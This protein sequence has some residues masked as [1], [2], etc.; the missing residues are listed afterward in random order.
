VVLCVNLVAP[1]VCRAVVHTMNEVKLP[2]VQEDGGA[3]T[4]SDIESFCPPMEAKQDGKDEGGSISS[5]TDPTTS[6]PEEK[7]DGESVDES[8]RGIKTPGL[9]ETDRIPTP[10][11]RT[12]VPREQKQACSSH[13]HAI[14]AFEA[15]VDEE[16]DT[17]D[18]EYDRDALVPCD[19]GYSK[20][21]RTQRMEFHWE[22]YSIAEWEN[23]YGPSRGAW[24]NAY[25]PQHMNYGGQYGN[26]YG[27]QYGH[28]YGNYRPQPYGAE[29]KRP[30]E[31]YHVHST[32]DMFSSSHYG[33]PPQKTKKKNKKKAKSNHTHNANANANAIGTWGGP[34]HSLVGAGTGEGRSTLPAA[35]MDPEHR[36]HRLESRR[37]D[38]ARWKEKEDYIEYRRLVPKHARSGDDPVSP[39]VSEDEV[40]SM[41]KREWKYNCERWQRAVKTRVKK[42]YENLESLEHVMN[43][44]S[45]AEKKKEQAI[46]DLEESDGA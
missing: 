4:S 5:G 44:I 8:T 23:V 40:E 26:Q 9:I 39:R 43:R 36:Q 29:R 3:T 21:D 6:P 41:S 14:R 30:R 7:E 25:G 19:E 12:S 20:Y 1:S 24:E 10:H 31:D 38:V 33:I 2:Q 27:N 17:E 28:Q 15:E 11:R 34:P 32:H 13:R 16:G 22:R 42:A 18:D 35:C 45:D 37:K 46:A